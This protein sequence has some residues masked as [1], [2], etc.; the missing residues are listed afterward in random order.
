MTKE[1]FIH[2][3][4]DASLQVAKA[5]GISPLFVL[6]QSAL[7]TGWGKSIKGNMMF[8]IKKGAGIN[9]GGWQGDIQLLTTTEYTNSPLFT[10]P[11]IYPGYPKLENGRWKSKVKT[12]FRAYSTPY[13][14]FRDWVGMLMQ[15]T[16]YQNAFN[17][18]EDPFRFAQEIVKAGYATDPNYIG[19]I[20]T[21]LYEISDMAKRVRRKR[22]KKKKGFEI[23]P[24]RVLY[25]GLMVSFVSFLLIKIKGES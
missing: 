17:Y 15:N 5:T 4:Y 20:H 24:F 8:G 1:T 3:Y 6:A 23:P 22:P 14:S 9:Y 13:H 18:K 25:Y 11:Y 16:R 10:F 2:T 7:E 19:K 21:L 12:E